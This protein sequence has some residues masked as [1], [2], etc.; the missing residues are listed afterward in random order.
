MIFLLVPALIC[1]AVG[2]LAGWY[3]RD[4]HQRYTE[5]DDVIARREA[6]DALAAMCES[7]DALEVPPF[8]VVVTPFD[9][10]KQ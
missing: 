1:A 3:L 4:L 10:A 7:V 9:W 5:F 2:M 6:H 8:E